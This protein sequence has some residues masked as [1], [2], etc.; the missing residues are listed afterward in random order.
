[1]E[2][3]DKEFHNKSMEKLSQLQRN[4]KESYLC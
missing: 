3:Q 1:M 4:E 2:T